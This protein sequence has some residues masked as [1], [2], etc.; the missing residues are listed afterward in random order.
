M[1]LS[2]IQTQL[3]ANTIS[4]QDIKW[5]KQLVNQLSLEKRHLHTEDP[6]KT[7]QDQVNTTDIL[8]LLDLVLNVT[9]EWVPNM[10][11][12]LILIQQLGNMNQIMVKLSPNWKEGTL[13]QKAEDFKDQLNLDQL[14]EITQTIT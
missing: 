12:N 4:I 5:A 1:N 13:N 11:L 8:H 6:R 2:Q 3:Q 10:F 7:H 14:Q 9:L